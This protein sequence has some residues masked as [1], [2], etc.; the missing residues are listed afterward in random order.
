MSA[1]RKCP[2]GRCAARARYARRDVDSGD[3]KVRGERLRGPAA[4][5]APELEHRR[6]TGQRL[7]Y[8]SSVPSPLL[9]ANRRGPLCMA[10]SDAVVTLCDESFRI[11]SLRS[12][13]RSGRLIEKYTERDG[14]TKD[15]TQELPRKSLPGAPKRP[16]AAYVTR[17]TFTTRCLRRFGTAHLAMAARPR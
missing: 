3:A 5:A 13:D 15:F 16:K 9:G 6:A 4:C 8:T 17:A 10:L 12:R 2:T 14:I 11:V 7:D 1:A